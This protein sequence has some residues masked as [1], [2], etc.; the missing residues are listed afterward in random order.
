MS[1]RDPRTGVLLANLGTPDSPSVPDVRRYLREFLSDPLVI[2]LPAPLRWLLL[3]AV[4]LPFRPR[5]SAHAYASIWTPEGSPLLVHGRALAKAL[6][7]RLG[8]DLPVALGMRYGQPSIAEAVDALRAAGAARLVAVPLFPQYAAS[9]TGSAIARAREVVAARAPALPLAIAPPFYA[10]PGFIA[11]FAARARPALAAFRPDHVLLSY[12][13]L[14]ERH[15]RREDPTGRHC[16]ASPSCCDAIVAANANCYRA[17]SFAT[18]RALAAALALPAGRWSV[19]FQSRLGGGWIQPFTDRVLPELAERGVRR[20]AI[21]C[22]SFVADCLET[23][24]EIGLRA[25]EQWQDLGGTDFLR[26]PCPNAEP[27]W[28]EALAG[29]VR[30]AARLAPP[31]ASP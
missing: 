21:A 7:A 5:R 16:L 3:N 1:E 9:S 6:G 11:A 12:H 28:V 15:V 13:G 2:D 31:P 27:E 22:P 14:P 24:E 29:L 17:Q 23:L 4:I 20:L 26:V 8:P 25:R 10:A 30:E 19:A 18:S